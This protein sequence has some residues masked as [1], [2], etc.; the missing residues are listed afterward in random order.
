MKKINNK[1]FVLAETLIVSVFILAIFAMI[2]TYYYPLIGSYEERET[3]DDV[4]GKYVAYWVKQLIESDS[5][6][7]SG[8]IF[9]KDNKKTMDNFGYIR[10]ECRDVNENDNRRKMCKNLV[11]ALEISK[12]DSEGNNCDIFITHFQIG[13]TQA[14]KIKP[15]FKSTVNG[16][17]LKYDKSSL[18]DNEVYLKKY[19][20]YTLDSGKLC[21]YA[22]N[23]NEVQQCKNKYLKSCFQGKGYK[24][25][26]DNLQTD[27]SISLTNEILSQRNT[28][29]VI[30]YCKN[31]SESKIFPSYLA[32]YINFL[33]NY[34]KTNYNSG[35]NYRVIVVTQ[36]KK[37][38]N[39]YYSF[40]TMEVN[41]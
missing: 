27:G 17:F 30:E 40:S 19:Q 33:P 7:F 9:E 5:Y 16:K 35:A 34:T 41:K 37:A 14:K 21:A 24:N 8:N 23:D 39:N 25:L 1:G 3:Y 4:D 26:A 12:C 31:Q 22:T 38:L 32:D 11:N 6:D 15:D 2:Y 18:I 29:D 36:H 13:G 28:I 10:F 20:E